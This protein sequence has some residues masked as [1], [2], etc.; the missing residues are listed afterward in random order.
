MKRLVEPL[1]TDE[2]RLVSFLK[3]SLA[4]EGGS[5]LPFTVVMRLSG[6]EPGS[7]N[8]SNSQRMERRQTTWRLALVLM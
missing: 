5:R 4:P 6:N 7:E 3:K 2:L 1:K 8:A